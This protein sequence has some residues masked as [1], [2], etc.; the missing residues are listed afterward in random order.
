MLLSC[1]SVVRSHGSE[2]HRLIIYC[3]KTVPPFTSSKCVAFHSSCTLSVLMSLGSL[4]EV[5]VY[6]C[7]SRCYFVPLFSIFCTHHMSILQCLT[8]SIQKT[9]LVSDIFSA[10]C[11][12][13]AEAELPVKPRRWDSLLCTPNFSPIESNTA[14]LGCHNDRAG[15]GHSGA[16]VLS[17]SS[18]MCPDAVLNLVTYSSGGMSLMDTLWSVTCKER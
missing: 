18:F 16:F 9:Q 11:S 4:Y 17:V 14:A 7:L 8:L 10:L 5:M 12:Y 1:L 3:V 6:F 13:R 2:L 15:T